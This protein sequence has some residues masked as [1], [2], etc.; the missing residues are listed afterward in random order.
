M[1]PMPAR[2]VSRLILLAALLAAVA[3]AAGA[4]GA[5][6]P[7]PSPP[8]GAPPPGGE[9]PRTEPPGTQPPPGDVP[10]PAQNGAPQGIGTKPLVEHGGTAGEALAF[11]MASR[12]YRTIRDLKSIM[13]DGLKA[14]YDKDPTPYNGKKGIRLSAFDYK[15]PAPAP[16]AKAV[17][18]T[19]RSLWE[20]QGEA[21]DLRTET[22]RLS[23]EAEGP[24]RVAAVQRGA[25]EAVRF[26]EA[27]A[28]VTSL[29]T[30]LRAWVRRDFEG[31]RSQ[32]T[33]AFLGRQAGRPDG[34][35]TIFAGDPNVRRA[36]FRIVQMTPRGTT[37]ALAKVRLVETPPG[38]PASLDGAARTLT[39]AKKGS[40]W[41]LDDWR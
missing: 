10:A 14:S 28:G 9:P 20:D 11:F 2:P 34:I 6:T 30:I 31:A 24:W 18:V 7:A 12:D 22:V 35:E 32:M 3:T 39:L 29:R 23:H 15:E 40:R 41:L 5:Q 8:P 4:L 13:T 33:E 26:R 36:A 37:G 1:M 25:V 16:T 38:R 27:F 21:V 19:V 17:S